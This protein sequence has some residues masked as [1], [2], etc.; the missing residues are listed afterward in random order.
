MSP[1]PM[2]RFF[3]K[4]FGCQMNFAESARL[5]TWLVGSGFEETDDPEKA[6]LLIFN[7]CGVRRSAEERLFGHIASLQRRKGPR[8]FC[9]AGCVANLR[10]EEIFR[11]H[12]F[13]DILCSGSRLS[14]LPA[15]YFEAKEK[16]RASALGE[17]LPSFVSSLPAAQGIFCPVSITKG[18][19]NYCSYCVVPYARGKLV[20][21][22]ADDVAA[23]VRGMVER[24]IRSF[25]LLGQNVNEYGRD[26]KDSGG[27]PP[28]LG[29][30]A[31]MEGVLRL[32]FLTSHP[33]DTG[34]DLFLVMARHGNINRYLHMP[35]QSASDGVL[36]RMNRRYTLGDYERTVASARLLVPDIS[37]GTDIIVGFPGETS[38]DFDET[39]RFLD[40]M[41]FEDVFIFQYSER[42]GTAAAR[43]FKDDVPPAEKQRRHEL[44]LSLQTRIMQRKKEES[45]GTTYEVLIERHAEKS[46]GHLIGRTLMG[47]AVLFPGN[48]SLGPGDLTTVTVTGVKKGYRYGEMRQEKP[49]PCPPSHQSV[50]ERLSS[51][52]KRG[53]S[54]GGN[55]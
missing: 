10:G 32:S 47:T 35:I 8:L 53:I 3:L 38:E 23:E 1:P 28:L 41:K 2:N 31:A 13:I 54:G 17:G 4:T 51:R 12:P 7:S 6:D 26:V 19:E 33:K 43:Q 37:I 46:A 30:I 5:K 29:N 11:T 21:K 44:A 40:R 18:C 9:L 50:L 22:P 14:E 34:E 52:T 48:G 24:G 49:S 42:P 16:G 36:R 25:L 55:E 39:L 15:L 20:S 27:F 45:F